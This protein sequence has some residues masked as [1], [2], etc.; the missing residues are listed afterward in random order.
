M[1]KYIFLPLKWYF[2]SLLMNSFFLLLFSS[3]FSSAS[4]LYFSLDLWGEEKILTKD[5]GI[6]L[7]SASRHTSWGQSPFPS[8]AFI[9]LI[10]ILINSILASIQK[11]AFYVQGKVN[12]RDEKVIFFTTISWINGRIWHWTMENT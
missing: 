10:N 1:K 6:S 4:K 2:Q 8:S 5:R 11:N 7:L 3:F 12:Y 9:I